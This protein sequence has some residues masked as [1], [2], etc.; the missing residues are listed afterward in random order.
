MKNSS[1]ITTYTKEKAKKKNKENKTDTN[2]RISEHIYNFFNRYNKG[3]YTIKNKENAKDENYQKLT[4]V[5]PKILDL[6]KRDPKIKQFLINFDCP[7]DLILYVETY[8]YNS[9]NEI[10]KEF[11]FRIPSLFY[12]R[13]KFNHVS[14]YISKLLCPCCSYHLLCHSGKYMLILLFKYF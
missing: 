14:K 12:F 11:L 9:Y 10:I 5:E 3:F 1:N 2:P 7:D 8:F 13:M 6:T 4:S